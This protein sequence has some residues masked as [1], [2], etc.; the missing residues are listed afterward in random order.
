MCVEV[1]KCQFQ[2]GASR[3]QAFGMFGVI[4]ICEMFLEVNK[5]AGELD[6]AFEQLGVAVFQ[7]EEF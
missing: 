6:Q 7:P 3:A 1:F 4:G 2:E 5:S